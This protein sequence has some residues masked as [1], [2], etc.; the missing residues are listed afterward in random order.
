MVILEYFV[1]FWCWNST[2]CCH[3]NKFSMAL[4]SWYDIFRALTA[5]SAYFPQP[6]VHLFKWHKMLVCLEAIFFTGEQGECVLIGWNEEY[7]IP[8]R[9]NHC[10]V[11]CT[12]T[13]KIVLA[14]WALNA[15]HAWIFG[16]IWVPSAFFHQLSIR[17]RIPP[18]DWIVQWEISHEGPSSFGVCHRSICHKS[19][20]KANPN[21]VR[22]L[23]VLMKQ[24]KCSK[25]YALTALGKILSDTYSL[26][27]CILCMW[28]STDVN[29]GH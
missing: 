17:E 23:V 7:N 1:S 15:R 3:W 9:F 20:I 27:I 25:F 22:Y 5:W 28:H 19:L 2:R 24:L 14:A 4:E 21:I 29:A 8:Q 11:R 13:S 6:L 10:I 18:G 16:P 26:C 12:L